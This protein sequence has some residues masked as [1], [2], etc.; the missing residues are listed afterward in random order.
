MGAPAGNGNGAAARRVLTFDAHR[1]EY[2]VDGIVKPSVTELLEAAGLTVDYRAIP[3]AV[4]LNAR[5]RGI[6]VDACCDLYDDGDLD[7]S[8]VHSDAV[9]YVQAWGR[10]CA[11]QGYEPAASQVQLYHPEHDYC[12]TAD[13]VG[14]VGRRW[15]LVDRKATTKVAASYGCQLAGYAMPGIECAE[16]A[17]E[18]VPVPWP[19]PAR[20]VVQL[21]P[22]GSY[23]VVPYDEPD[24][25][26]A[27]LGAIALHRWRTARGSLNAPLRLDARLA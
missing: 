14:T 27:F 5:M 2:R 11:E 18:L 8:T 9:P 15:V 25:V 22:D 12:G 13:S 20:A 7:W 3:A 4:L 6:H 1:H 16:H 21:R 23:R 17:G 19:P 26:A 10:F 24:D